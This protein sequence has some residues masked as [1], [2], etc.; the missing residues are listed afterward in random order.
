[1]IV[2]LIRMIQSAFHVCVFCIHGFNQLQI[3]N[4]QEKKKSTK[5]PKAK[6]EL[7]AC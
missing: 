3:E 5:F 2:A 7:A 1:M 4:I 6:L